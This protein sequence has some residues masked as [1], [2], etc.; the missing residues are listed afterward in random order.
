MRGEEIVFSGGIAVAQPLEL[1]LAHGGFHEAPVAMLEL[2]LLL[3]G[4]RV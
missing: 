1:H 4:L 2:R 3:P